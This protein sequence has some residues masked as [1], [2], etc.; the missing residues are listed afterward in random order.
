M[1]H[2]GPYDMDNQ[3][4]RW[5]IS[6]TILAKEY[7]ALIDKANNRKP[8][9]KESIDFCA[10]LDKSIRKAILFGKLSAYSGGH[11]AQLEPGVN[12]YAN[13]VVYLHHFCTWAEESLI[14]CPKEASVLAEK[15]GLPLYDEQGTENSLDKV[16]ETR[17]QRQDRRLQACIDA[18]LLMEIHFKTRLPDGVGMAASREGVSRQAFSKDVRAALERRNEKR[19]EGN[20]VNT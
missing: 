9:S 8:D 4:S 11:G 3:I 20:T 7:S 6:A 15:M 5:Y 1:P 2:M 18:G 14:G 19:K 16:H 12:A 17:E 10:N 13:G